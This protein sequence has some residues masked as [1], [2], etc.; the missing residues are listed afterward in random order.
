MPSVPEGSF[1]WPAPSAVITTRYRV[2]KRSSTYGRKRPANRLSCRAERN[3]RIPRLRQLA[4]G[5]AQRMELSGPRYTHVRL[6]S[7]QCFQPVAGLEAI[8]AVQLQLHHWL[9]HA[10]PRN[11]SR[12]IGPRQRPRRAG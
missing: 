10:C 11:P 12:H 6:V 4:D 3:E 8:D 9:A 7:D 1:A 2:E 5:G